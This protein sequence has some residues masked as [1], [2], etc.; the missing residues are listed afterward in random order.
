M[1]SLA[2]LAALAP[3]ALAKSLCGQFQHHSSDGYYFNN[4][5]WGAGTAD[6]KQC[7]VVDKTAR[8]GVS[9]H[10]DWTWSG[11]NK[12]NVKAYPYAGRE[13]GTKKKVS[14]ID[15]IPTT[16]SWGYKGNARAN[17]AYDLFT[18]ADPNHDESSGDYELM[19]WLGK[20]G[21]VWPIGPKVG[22]VNIGGMDW[23]LHDGFN[24]D[25]HVYSFVA[26]T[27]RKSFKGDVKDYF[28]YLTKHKDF[29][30]DKQHLLILQFGSEPF[31]GGPATFTVNSWSG[32]VE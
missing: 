21:E 28:D 25:M 17:V 22:T 30:A 7:L 31:N 14:S 12:N 3:L 19:I 15:S 27:P 24:G 6:G 29:P 9:Y 16:A 20:I 2:I 26:P 5:M 18:A 1:K 13:L 4:N 32:S 8:D 23:D 11:G 10:V